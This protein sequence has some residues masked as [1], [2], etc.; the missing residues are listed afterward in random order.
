VNGRQLIV[1]ADDTGH[2][3]VPLWLGGLDFKVRRAARPLSAAP[4][5]K[6][7]VWLTV[8]CAAC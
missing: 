4:A 8:F 6:D 2:R 1:L 7:L 5:P 3:A